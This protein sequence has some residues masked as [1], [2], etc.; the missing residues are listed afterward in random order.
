M[1]LLTVVQAIDLVTDEALVLATAD[2]VATTTKARAAIQ[3]Y[4]SIIPA[5]YRIRTSA[6]VTL[7]T[8]KAING[9]G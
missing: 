9:R 5:T 2:S 3:K 4:R 1:L 7:V 6:S 8:L